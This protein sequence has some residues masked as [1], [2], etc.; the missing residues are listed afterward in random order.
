MAGKTELGIAR[1]GTHH[2]GMVLAG[3]DSLFQH[4][5]ENLQVG[6][7]IVHHKGRLVASR[8]AVVEHAGPAGV[9][10]VR[11]K[12]QSA[13]FKLPLDH[14]LLVVYGDVVNGQGKILDGE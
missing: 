8:I 1:T 13:L 6:G 12:A 4:V 2:R 14:A 9:L 3:P 7:R 11:Q 5:G 10:G